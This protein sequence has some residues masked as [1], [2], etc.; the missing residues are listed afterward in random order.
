MNDHRPCGCNEYQSLSRRQFLSRGV[1]S[2]A[3][4]ASAPAWLPRVS[5]AQSENSARDVMVSVFFRGGADGLSLCVPH[6][7]DAY[8]NARPTLAIP[9]PDSGSPNAAVDLDGFFGFAPA[10]AALVSA[11]DAGDLLVVHATG[12]Q[13]ETRSHFDAMKFMEVG[14]PRDPNLA[15]GWLGR[16]LLT[17]TPSDSSA[18]L[19]AIGISPGLQQ[20]LVGAPLAL[21]VPDPDEFTI[22]GNDATASERVAALANMYQTTEEPLVTSA[23]NTAAVI[24]LLDAID[25]QGYTPAGGAEYPNSEFGMALKSTAALIKADLGLEAVAI[26]KGGWDTHLNQEPLDGHMFG[27]MSDLAA[28]LAAFHLDLIANGN[29]NVV[30]TCMSEFGRNVRQNASQGTDHGHGN[31]LFAMGQRV[32]GGAVLTNWPGLEAGQLYEGQD[33]DVTIDYR[34]IL[35]EI[36]QNLLDNNDLS[37]VFPDYTPTFRGVTT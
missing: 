36:V 7:E 30:L 10:M 24:A 27:L 28:A 32:A 1:A 16:H 3:A 33:L 35:A 34:D 12:S 23:E 5:F 6:G 14:K 13:D 29:R 22:Y 37:F 4:L 17:V 31:C 26:D 8:Y 18:L 20:T 19:R 15:T 9:R 21:P 2:A 25:F 11:F